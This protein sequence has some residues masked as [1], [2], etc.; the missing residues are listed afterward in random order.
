[1]R[2]ELIA[3]ELAFRVRADGRMVFVKTI[4][5]RSKFARF[6]EILLKTGLL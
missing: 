2:Y 3:H 6:L 5:D 1:M 4:E